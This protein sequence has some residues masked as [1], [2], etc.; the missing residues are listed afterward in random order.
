MDYTCVNYNVEAWEGRAYSYGMQASTLLCFVCQTWPARQHQSCSLSGYHSTSAR[1]L[2]RRRSHAGMHALI[3]CM[4]VQSVVE[5][6]SRVCQWL[7]EAGCPVEGLH[8]DPDL[9]TRGLIVDKA[10]GNLLKARMNPYIPQV[11]CR[12]GT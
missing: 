7:R 10:L 12:G 1:F 9:V 2:C 5:L 11:C 8:F 3:V 6:D 4:A